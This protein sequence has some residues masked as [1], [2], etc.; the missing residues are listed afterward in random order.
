MRSSSESR[1]PA[2]DRVRFKAGVSVQRC[3]LLGLSMYWVGFFF[4]FCWRWENG[5]GMV[6]RW[7][8]AEK[9]KHRHVFGYHNNIHFL[10]N[11]KYELPE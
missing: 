9:D 3:N 10:T 7:S 5:F 4:F 6:K 8:T 1:G 2:R 11:S